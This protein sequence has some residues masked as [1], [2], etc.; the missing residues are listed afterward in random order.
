MT[1]YLQHNL[2]VLQRRFP[3]LAQATFDAEAQDVLEGVAQWIIDLIDDPDGNYPFETGNLLE[4][5]A[6]AVY[7]D[8]VVRVFRTSESPTQLQEWNGQWYR[9]K[10]QLRLALSYGA[11]NFGS[12]VW[13]VLFAAQP[14]ANWLNEE[15]SGHIGF[16]TDLSNEMKDLVHERFRSLSRQIRIGNFKPKAHNDSSATF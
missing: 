12:G 14:Y 16:F 5:T 4:S 15:H 13:I 6:V 2:G 11:S 9:G 3:R 8:G 10:E 1:N 7:T